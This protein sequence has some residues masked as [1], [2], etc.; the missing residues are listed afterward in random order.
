MMVQIENN[1]TA[2]PPS[3]LGLADLVIEAP[4]EGDTTRFNAIFACTDR[5]GEA[6]GPIRSA[7]YFNLDLWQQMRGLTFHFGGAAKVI[8]TFRAAN[9]PY[10]NG[11]SGIWPYFFRAGPWAAPHNVYLDLDAAR[12]AMED[13]DL[14]GLAGAA[15]AAGEPRGPFT[16]DPVADV[17]EGRAVGG[18]EIWASSFWHYGWDWDADSGTWLRSDGGAANFEALTGERLFADAVVVQI[19]RQDVLIGENDPGGHPRRYQHLVDEGEGLLYINGQVHDLRWSRPDAEDLTTWT[20]T[21]GGDPLVLPPGKVWWEII[22]IG[23]G[24]VER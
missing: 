11:I 5:V 1:P 10:V 20:Y 15:V 13:G 7:R 3:G 18:V 4:V 8:D 6:V 19:V 21:E 24:I 14:A 12:D 9:M 23:S 17:P 22:P 2:R 16:F